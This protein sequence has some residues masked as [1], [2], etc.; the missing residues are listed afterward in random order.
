[1]EDLVET[2]ITGF[3]VSSLFIIL[4]WWF[5]RRYDQPSDAQLAREEELAKKTEEQKMW[6]AVEAQ[7]AQEK[8]EMEEQALYLRKK[9]EQQQRAQPPAAGALTNALDAF[10][11]VSQSPTETPQEAANFSGTEQAPT[12]G[13]SL[14]AEDFEEEQDLDV[15]LATAPVEVRQDRGV[16]AKDG[17][18]VAEPDWQLV[19][20]LQQLSEA[21]VV[22][23]VPHPE[24]PDAPD[25]EALTT[26]EL[27]PEASPEAETTMEPPSPTEPL[28]DSD[29]EDVVE[30]DPNDGPT[31]SGAWDVQWTVGDEEVD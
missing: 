19:E 25:L 1:V 22:E 10:G 4:V 31:D 5:W 23:E 17:D 13:I 26:P 9:A 29:P 3:I 21:E 24:L 11:D 7:I 15:L 27:P 18:P 2:L 6:R 12:E 14:T 30:W 20:K 28:I 8:A 16:L